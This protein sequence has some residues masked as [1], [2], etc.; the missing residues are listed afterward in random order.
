MK[1]IF[2]SVLSLM[3]AGQAWA[4]K[5]GLL[6]DNSGWIVEG[7]NTSSSYYELLDDEI[8]ITNADCNNPW[9]TQFS[10]PSWQKIG[11]KGDRFKLTFDVLYEGEEPSAKFRIA[12][13]KTYPHNP[14]FQS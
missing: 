7:I 12:S 11:K 10:T 2:V 4:Q 5:T 9:D 8:I 1:K 3:I 13:G 14:D 6:D